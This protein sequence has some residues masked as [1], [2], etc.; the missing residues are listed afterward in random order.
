MNTYP[1]CALI[2]MSMCGR[3]TCTHIIIQ[4]SCSSSRA[5]GWGGS[6][7][8]W[9]NP[10]FRPKKIKNQIT[11]HINYTVCKRY[12]DSTDYR[13][14]FSKQFYCSPK[15][16]VEARAWTLA[17]WP[18]LFYYVWEVHGYY[19]STGCIYAAKSSPGPSLK[20]GILFSELPPSCTTP[21]TWSH[22]PPFWKSWLQAWALSW[23]PW[24][25]ILHSEPCA[26]ALTVNK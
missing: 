16:D 2:C 9:T 12:T 5:L 4:C 18:C 20:I 19:R 26:N 14:S 15:C 13:V 21:C 8:V 22:E 25:Y 11:H 24:E 6:R 7:G 1:H 17:S 10:L 3:A 23:K